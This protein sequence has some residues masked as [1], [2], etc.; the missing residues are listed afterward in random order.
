[1]AIGNRWNYTRT[2]VAS[3]P[4]VCFIGRIRTSCRTIVSDLGKRELEGKP[5]SERDEINLSYQLVIRLP[6]RRMK[7]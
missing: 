2:P 7:S 5:L 3:L 1:M 6:E 4:P